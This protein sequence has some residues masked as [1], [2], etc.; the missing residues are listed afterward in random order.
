[1]LSFVDADEDARVLCRDPVGEILGQ[2][3]R[4][5]ASRLNQT[6]LIVHFISQHIP[7]RARNDAT[8]EKL[9]YIISCCDHHDC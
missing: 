3:E 4:S 6:R 2:T 7:Q 1:M 5:G 9:P 8:Y